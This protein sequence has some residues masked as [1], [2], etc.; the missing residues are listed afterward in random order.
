MQVCGGHNGTKVM[1]TYS[2]ALSGALGL[3]PDL[4]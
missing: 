3:T 2:R 1:G 4:F